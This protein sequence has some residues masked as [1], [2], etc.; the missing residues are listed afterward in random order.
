MS[1]GHSTKQ[2]K[3]GV[4]QAKSRQEPGRRWC[5]AE[6]VLSPSCS[7]PCV[8][9][10]RRVVAG[11]SSVSPCQLSSRRPISPSRQPIQQGWQDTRPCSYIPASPALSAARLP[12]SVFLVPLTLFC[13]ANSK[14]RIYT[15]L[16]P[17]ICGYCRLTVAGR[18]V[19]GR[20]GRG[21]QDDILPLPCSH[22]CV[23]TEEQTDSSSGL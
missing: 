1:P 10:Q 2:A 12:C 4:L 5:W 9:S 7:I 20:L 21:K 17:N 15:H 16:S 23:G 13:R 18:W 14:I 6:Q 11:R 3:R 22:W 19:L 8:N